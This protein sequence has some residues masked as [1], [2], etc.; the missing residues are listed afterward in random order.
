[1]VFSQLDPSGKILYATYYAGPN[2]VPTALRAV[3]V[4]PSG[5]AYVTG[6][7]AQGSDFLTEF[8][9]SNSGAASLVFRT[10]F[11]SNSTQINAVSSD[12]AGNAFITGGTGDPSFP[13]TIG[14]FQPTYPCCGSAFITEYTPSG[15]LKYSTLLGA[16]NTWVGR[17]IAVDALG[18][19]YVEGAGNNSTVIPA[20]AGTGDAIFM[21]RSNPALSG[22]SALLSTYFFFHRA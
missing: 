10:S 21:V 5:N 15:T 6:Y 11:A 18:I 19:V 8:N 4:A 20:T 22:S 13:T 1:M 12:P 3:A 9:P 16:G 7:D 2:N 17:Q 14:S